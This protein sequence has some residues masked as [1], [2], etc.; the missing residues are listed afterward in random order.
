MKLFVILLH[1]FAKEGNVEDDSQ[2]RLNRG[3]GEMEDAKSDREF[4]FFF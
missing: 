1:I 4:F 3:G 2:M